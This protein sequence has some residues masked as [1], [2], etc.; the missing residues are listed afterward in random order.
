MHKILRYFLTLAILTASAQLA[1]AQDCGC[2]HVV[3]PPTERATTLILKGDSIGVKAGQTV[4]LAAG[5]YMQIRFVNMHGEPG[6]PVT[7]QNCG[8]Q[9]QIGDDITYG[10]W[11]AVDLTSSSYV[12]LTGSGAPGIR[13][14]IKLGRSGD[15]GLKIGASTDAEIDHIEIANANFAGIMAK[16]D[17]RGNVPPD[18]PEMNNINI[19][20]NYIHDARGEGMY[21]GETTT[22]GQDFR[23]LE[24][25][26]NIVTRSG[27][28]LF[29]IANAIEDVRV[30]HNVLYKSGLRNVLYQNKG[31]QIG[32]NCVGEYYNNF[33]IGSPSNSMIVMGM[34]NIDIYNNYFQGAGDPSF[35]VDNRKVTLPGTP[36]KIR[37]NYLMEVR[38]T[39]VFFNIFNE[40]NNVS[41]TGNRLEGSNTIIGTDP[42]A[43]EPIVVHNSDNVVGLIERVQF[44]DVTIDDFT[45][46]ENSPYQG[47]GLLEDVS[48]RNKRPFIA[49]IPKQVLEAE[50]TKQIPVKA[51]DADG[52][53]LTLEAFNLPPFVTFVDNGDGTG[54]FNLAPQLSDIGVHHKVRVRVTDAKGGMNT[55]Y[56]SINVKDPYAFIATA[57]ASTLNNGP[58]NTLDKNMLTR[59]EGGA[60]AGNWIK[61][62][63]REDKLVSSVQIAFHNGATTV[64]PFVIETSEDNVTWSH[65]M[66]AASSGSSIDLETFSLGEI[67][68][69][70]MRISDAGVE[71]NSYNEVV[72]A[73]K[74]APV[75]HEYTTS[76]DVYAD[77][78][79]A[80]NNTILKVR[81]DRLITYLRFDVTGLNVS[82]S[83]VIASRLK[84]KAVL[85]GYGKI[86]V[87]LGNNVEWSETSSRNELPSK[88]RALTSLTTYFTAGQEYEFDLADAVQDN[89]IVNIILTAQNTKA[90]TLGFS[91]SEGAQGPQLL[92]TT[93]RGG[94]P[95][96]ESD[97]TMID[98]AL[99][100]DET[101]ARTT[102]DQVTVFPN[103]FADE[104]T[105]DFDEEVD[106]VMTV[107]ISDRTGRQVFTQNWTNPGSSLVLDMQDLNMYPGMYILKVK[108]DGVE[109]K[110]LRIFKR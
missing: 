103:P 87:Y 74:T 75:T 30:H 43:P 31:F 91:P 41:I 93:L 64:Q 106:G 15:S 17:Y 97:G 22:P 44:T 45:L 7:I 82:K 48:G 18:A 61:Y 37:D 12:R 84:V 98:M 72:I 10:R 39:A 42:L 101:A 70:Y 78:K 9:V 4:C 26:N 56:Y 62:D 5:F 3:S 2:D 92:V 47:I 8:G 34:G 71:P 73:C 11:W 105:V 55:Q 102:F 51:G 108:Q 36:I 21:I 38:E 16:T 13:Y 25:W 107:E 54:V 69:R 52:E 6:N 27:L 100:S 67:R 81:E 40:L 99:T 95:V 19:H 77:D 104:I 65:V 66:S 23:H 28:D 89:G 58:E 83:P 68:A 90:A 80:Y 57:N 33:V 24:I 20:D 109:S 88:G 96:S 1:E 32:D 50:T 76:A 63:L 59:W 35:F 85:S 53:A 14:G 49:I 29:Q 79:K 110:T 86:A 94:L 46:P 60:P